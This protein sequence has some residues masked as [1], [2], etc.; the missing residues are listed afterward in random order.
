MGSRLVSR[1]RKVTEG[2]L[3]QERY[4]EETHQPET[5]EMRITASSGGRRITLDPIG[6]GEFTIKL[7]IRQ[8]ESTIPAGFQVQW[9]SVETEEFGEIALNAGAG[10][11]SP[12]GTLWLGKGEGH[13]N[14]IF[15]ANDLI[16]A[17]VDAVRSHD[18]ASQKENTE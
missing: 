12:Y 6:M 10:V 17:I 16:N 5:K 1:K 8:V 4:D 18:T 11:G 15:N 14:F 13:R 2:P 3:T 7:P 9:G